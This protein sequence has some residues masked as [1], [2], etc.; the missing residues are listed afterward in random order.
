LPHV[1]GWHTT[2]SLVAVSVLDIGSLALYLKALQEDDTSVVVS[3]FSIGKI[4]VPIVAFF[5]IGERLS[6]GQYVGFLIVV[7][8]VALLTMKVR[9]GRLR[10]SKGFGLMLGASLLNSVI[11]II[12]KQTLEK[13][14]WVTAVSYC[15]VLSFATLTVIT[16]FRWKRVADRWTVLKDRLTILVLM[17]LLSW[18][19][20]IAGTI[21]FSL[22]AVTLVKG[23]YATQPL[24]V[25]VY[26]FLLRRRCPSSFREHLSARIVIRKALL[27]L[28][29]AATMVFVLR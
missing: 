2:L 28:V 16:L 8:C 17:A 14:D 26:T 11:A 10:I 4:C 7:L 1:L 15:A 24:F 9:T 21:A 20:R 3:L 29:I 23:V 13:V 27:F 19:S 5:A 25:L 18:V 22:A 12:Y 6:L